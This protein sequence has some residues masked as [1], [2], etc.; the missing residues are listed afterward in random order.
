[1]SSIVKYAWEYIHGKEF[2]DYSV[3]HVCGQFCFHPSHA[4]DANRR[5]VTDPLIYQIAQIASGDPKAPAQKRK[6]SK[7][8]GPER[9]PSPPPDAASSSSQNA[10][11]QLQLVAVRN[12][13]LSP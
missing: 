11:L 8:T 6:S 12:N 9:D 7:I 13:K 10:P 4:Y 2:I 3:S 1:M 5:K